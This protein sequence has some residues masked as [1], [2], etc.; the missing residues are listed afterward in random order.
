M[1]NTSHPN[2]SINGARSPVHSHKVTYKAVPCCHSGRT[3]SFENDNEQEA[4]A[5]STLSHCHLLYFELV[6]H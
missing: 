2:T 5:I 6:V 4:A 3:H 1:L